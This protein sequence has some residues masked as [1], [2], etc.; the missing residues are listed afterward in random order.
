M[1]KVTQKEGLVPGAPS[2][3]EA[4]GGPERSACGLRP[5]ERRTH[6]TLARLTLQGEQA[7]KPVL[8]GPGNDQEVHAQGMHFPSEGE[9][10]PG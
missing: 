9:M 8:V 5:C 6:K 2:P 1:W 7:G 4:K 3:G 10:S